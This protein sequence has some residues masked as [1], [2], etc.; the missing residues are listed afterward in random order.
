MF[1][2]SL[3][4]PQDKRKWSRNFLFFY[5]V[6]DVNSELCESLNSELQNVNSDSEKKSQNCEI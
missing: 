3:F 4:P 2:G 1:Y 6:Q 5:S